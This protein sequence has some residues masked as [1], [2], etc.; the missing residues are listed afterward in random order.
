MRGIAGRKK[1]FVEVISDTSTEGVVTPLAVVWQTGTRYNIDRVLDA[2]QARSLK[3][4][5]VGM[6]YTVQIGTKQTYLWY[7]DAC[8]KWF[9]EA[10]V[11]SIPE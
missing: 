8:G 5:S 3:T 1:Q 6:R 10:K 7:D 9:V 11:V 2:R 4:G